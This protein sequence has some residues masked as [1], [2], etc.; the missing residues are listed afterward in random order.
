ML[1]KQLYILFL[2]SIGFEWSHHSKFLSVVC[3]SKSTHLKLV[4][5]GYMIT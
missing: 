4:D 2:Q 1:K 3:K 5:L